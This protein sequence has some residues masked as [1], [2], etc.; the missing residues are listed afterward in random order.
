MNLDVSSFYGE[1]QSFH[2]KGDCYLFTKFLHMVMIFYG[3]NI[4]LSLKTIKQ[5][6]TNMRSLVNDELLAKRVVEVSKTM[7]IALAKSFYSLGES[8]MTTSVKPVEKIKH[9]VNFK[10]IEYKTFM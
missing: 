10:V 2:L 8:F 1:L 6:L 3:D 9:S 4:Q 7:D 5:F